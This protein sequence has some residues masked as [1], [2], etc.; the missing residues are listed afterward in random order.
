M[1]DAL[2]N[3]LAATIDSMDTPYRP[4]MTQS[5]S[6][7]WTVWVMGVGAAAVGEAVDGPAAGG[8]GAGA[9]ACGMASAWPMRMNDGS[10]SSFASART[11]TVVP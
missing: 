7:A 11:G 2:A 8:L 9:A 4:E 1:N 6:P 5:V 3:A 10:G